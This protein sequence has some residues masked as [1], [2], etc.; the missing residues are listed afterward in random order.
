MSRPGPRVMPAD[1]IPVVSP[2]ISEFFNKLIFLVISHFLK[3]IDL[4]QAELLE[5]VLQGDDG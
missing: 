5:D 3:Q 1:G 2:D 4:D